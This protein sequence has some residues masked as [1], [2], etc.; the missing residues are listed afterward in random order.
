MC[1][2]SAALAVAAAAAYLW[3]PLAAVAA[4]FQPSSS[5]Q[6]TTHEDIRIAIFS[7]ART[8]RDNMDKL[9]RHERREK[10]SGDQIQN[11]LLTIVN[12][13][14][15]QY[16]DGKT[17][18]T[19]VK[20]L[21]QSLNAMIAAE[22]ERDADRAN[23]RALVEGLA[24]D[25]AAG[26]AELRSALSDGRKSSA[27]QYRSLDDKIGAVADRV[28][29][30]LSRLDA[31]E[32]TPAKAD[33]AVPDMLRLLLDRTPAVNGTSEPAL[34][35]GAAV[36]EAIRALG[37][38]LDDGDRRRDETGGRLLA[39]ADATKAFQDDVQNSFRL[40]SDEV[41][42]LSDVQK[43]LAQTADNVLD[44]KRRVEYG[45]HQILVEVAAA[46]G[47]RARELNASLEAGLELVTKTAADAQAAVMG[48]LSVKIETEISQVWRQ[49]GIMYQTLTDSAATLDAL[50]R[51]TDAFVNGTTAAVDGIDGK[52][53]A[54]GGR[55]AEVD[56]NLNYLLGRL[57][58]VTQEFRQ[59]KIGL[60]E[61]L[62]S[63]RVGL[64]AA[65][66]AGNGTA[67]AGGADAGPGPNPIDDEPLSENVVNPDALSKTV[68]TVS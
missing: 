5:V 17:L 38:R 37:A 3:L 27:E 9:E 60:G 1:F 66:G 50:R 59:I 4:D 61:A 25:A 7:V 24:K 42:A 48:N 47:D 32:R 31:A 18:E 68:Y 20:G 52:V 36:L 19:V 40:M 14:R 65:R 15:E 56:D 46:V 53:S 44:T 11:M 58:L 21:E 33:D 10:Q 55:M 23:A 2:K 57:S 41:K 34:E 29:A 39:A 49:I 8:L 12:K 6:E 22:T 28:D 51:Q 63:I 64:H 26:V 67:A 43:T 45:T 54:V 35:A 30:I 62:D 13:Q 16:V